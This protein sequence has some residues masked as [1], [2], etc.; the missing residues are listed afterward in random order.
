MS[1]MKRLLTTGSRDWDRVDI[2]RSALHWAF[3]KLGGGEI[4]LVSGACPTGADKLA[5]DF[6]ES[7]GQPIE[8]HPA[9]W[10]YNGKR[11]GFMRNQHMVNLGADLCWAFINDN[12][13][14]ATHCAEAAEKAGI[15]TH[16][17][18]TRGN[19]FS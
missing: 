3:E 13:R 14:G 11:A 2:I 15:E 17:V 12:S 8:R 1:E 19:H 18:R 7:L 16:I 4:V 9:N 6:W 10:K 5:E